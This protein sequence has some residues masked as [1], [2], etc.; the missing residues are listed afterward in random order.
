ML[1]E[2]IGLRRDDAAEIA[3]AGEPMPNLRSGP[4]P[5]VG[6]RASFL[7]PFDIALRRRHPYAWTSAL[8]GLTEATLMAPAW[9]VHAVPYYWLAREHVE[10]LMGEQPIPGYQPELEDEALRLI[11]FKPDSQTWVLHGDN[12]QALIET[13]F[14]DVTEQQSLIFFYLKHSPFEDAGRL[15]VG[16]A[17]VEGVTLPGRWPTNSPT[18]F[19]NHMWETVVRHT[20]RPDGSGGLLL[21][22]QELADLAATGVDVSE[23][24][25]VAPETNR[26]FSYVTEHVPADAAVAALLALQRAAAGAGKLGLQVPAHSLTWLDTQLGLAW[27]RRGV[28]PGLPAVLAQIGF[29]YPTF[30]A[31]AIMGAV[32]VG[33]DPWP[34]LERALG[35]DLQIPQQVAELATRSRQRIWSKLSAE[36]KS[37]LRV[38]ARFDLTAVQVANV[39]AENTSIPMSAEDLLENPYHLVTCTIDDDEPIR[40]DVVDRGCYPGTGPSALHP[41]PVPD[42]PTDAVDVRRVEAVLADELATAAD[43]GHTLL[44]LS[45][46]LERLTART[47]SRSLPVTQL[48]LSGLDLTPEDL[49]DDP[50]ANWP[51][52]A[53]TPLAGGG[54][55]YKLRPSA[56]RA[57]VIRE[58]VAMLAAK[59]RHPVPADLEDALLEVLDSLGNESPEKPDPED[60]E[61]EKRARTEKQAA[62]RELWAAR[63]ST[64]NG[65]A[66]TG[67]TTLIRALAARPE[68]AAGGVLLLAPTGK[69]RVQLSH[70]TQREASTIAQF[71]AHSGRYDG[72]VGRYRVTGDAASRQRFGLVVVDEA[73][74]L[75]EDMLAALCDALV[76][77]DRFILVGDPRQLPPIGAGR[78]FVDL[79]R[80]GRER[81]DGGWPQVAPGWAALTVLRRQ[82]GRLRDD[83]ML[84]RW[85]SGDEIPEGFDEVW[86]RLRRCERMETLRAVAWNGRTPAQVLDAVLAEEL[87]VSDDDSGRSFAASYGA[88]LG[89]YINYFPAATDCE[90][91]QALSPFRGRSYGTVHLNRHLKNKYRQQELNWALLPHYSRTVP[92]P[93]GGERIVLGDKVVN[94]EN[95]PLSYWSREDGKR[96]GYIANGEIGVVIGQLKS[97][98]M[99]GPPWETQIEYSSQPGRR[100]RAARGGDDDAP[101]EL[102]WAL[103]VHKSQGSEFGVVV[104]MLPAGVRRLS[105]EL[106]YTA[107]T[108]QTRK[109]IVCHE[110]PLEDLLELTRASGSDT[111]RR[112]TDLT[113]PPRPA[114]V[115]TA[116]GTAAGTLDAGLVHVTDGGI[117]V[118]S[119][120]EV[121]IADILDNVAPGAWAYEQPL[122]GQ[123]GVSRLPDFTISTAD[124]RTV[125]WE[126]L[127]M[128]EDPQYA[129]G[130]ERK[131]RW[132]A[133]QGILP[134]ESNGGPAGWLVWTDDRKGVDKPAWRALAERV[135]GAPRAGTSAGRPRKITARRLT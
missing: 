14:G 105:R 67:K 10:Q 110:G 113:V 22:M 42:P 53:R 74:M 82:K 108:R 123:D 101:V 118:R 50:D 85:F 66:G 78:P 17:L 130:W 124:G 100:Y 40:F 103:T 18:K 25:A 81:H 79:E 49:D 69:A 114:N 21:P 35:G 77:P 65:P 57:R 96:R 128:L 39:L 36:T 54:Y 117:L 27:D 55:A 92:K 112:L 11:G 126:H 98:S 5:C 90:K 63:F 70:K 115:T 133:D 45:L 121:I 23:A 93:L 134:A 84:A 16:A 37:A 116:A 129:A 59:P 43:E 104:L 76:P 6:E 32:D 89:T 58:F 122:T 73:S 125:Y 4:P 19:P 120:N 41:L 131:K 31:R 106:L 87:G 80:A 28:T 62:L 3:D 30:D 1:L 47:Y 34:V 119:K 24:L 26:E 52:L 88:E 91:W 9:S 83:L 38:L 60:L 33:D 107:L 64:L 72:D 2:N 71:L 97:K 109:V 99:K 56:T 61:A 20:L 7:S 51:I 46:I 12:Q 94:L 127:G 68:V 44:P 86:E 8:K 48:V 132:Y 135:L 102:A 13:F 111:G 15:L 75:T 95:R 29:E